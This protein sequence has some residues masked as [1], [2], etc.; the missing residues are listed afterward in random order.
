[1]T[2]AEIVSKVR[3]IMNEIGE[4]QSL[5]LLSEDTL[6]LDD[7]IIS[8]LPDAVSFVQ[9]K[10]S[11]CVNKKDISYNGGG[12]ISSIAIPDDFVSLIAV[13]LNT[14]KKTCVALYTMND[15]EYKRQCNDYTK[16]G[17]NKPV[18]VM[19]F[20]DT[21]Q[22]FLL[23]PAADSIDIFAYEAQYTGTLSLEAEDSLAI[24]ICYKAASL[25]YAIFENKNQAQVM[26]ELAI[27]YI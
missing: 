11:R 19:G 20:N 2:E 13:K 27:S 3:A 16:S 1:M 26:N 21:E 24:A 22:S 18:V 14:W 17:V 10:S 8:A 4:E 15:E 6:K 12:K 9:T 25:V 23:F 5:T 7:Y